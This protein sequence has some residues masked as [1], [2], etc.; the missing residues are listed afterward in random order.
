MQS[1]SCI[2]K[3]ILALERDLS[4]RKE[5]SQVRKFATALSFYIRL[6]LFTLYTATVD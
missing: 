4:T 3:G 5:Q 6:L 1:D 2:L